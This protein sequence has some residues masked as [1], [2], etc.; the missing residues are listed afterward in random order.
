MTS[1][2]RASRNRPPGATVL[3]PFG[4]YGGAK[5]SPHVGDY[6]RWANFYAPELEGEVT[7][8]NSTT[9]KEV[10]PSRLTLSTTMAPITQS[11][12][13]RHSQGRVH[14][15]NVFGKVLP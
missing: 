9:T 6:R 15:E 14:T 1:N 2:T 13:I 4:G 12:S 5:P 7:G 11:I 3:I 10:Q 8:N